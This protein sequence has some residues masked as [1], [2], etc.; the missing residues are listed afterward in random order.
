M[1]WCDPPVFFWM[2]LAECARM[3]GT[4][5]GRVPKRVCSLGP[6][7]ADFVLRRCRGDEWKAVGKERTERI[8]RH[9]T[10][11]SE[12]GGCSDVATRNHQEQ[13]ASHVLLH[14]LSLT[15]ISP[16]MRNL[17]IFSPDITISLSMRFRFGL[18]KFYI[19]GVENTQVWILFVSRRALRRAETMSCK[20]FRSATCDQPYYMIT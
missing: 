10:R 18:L 12:P 8:T 2:A 4:T 15:T 6:H 13:L 11:G 7:Y 9:R 14:L 16:T 3:P 19:W 1:G 20:L 17:Q 5:W